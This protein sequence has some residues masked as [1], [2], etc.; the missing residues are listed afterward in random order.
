MIRFI[1]VSY[2]SI[3]I[4]ALAACE[5]EYDRLS[6]RWP[7][8][9]PPTPIEGTLTVL[10]VKFGIEEFD[11]Q[12]ARFNVYETS[13]G[14]VVFI[15]HVETGACTKSS[16]F[17]ET[18]SLSPFIEAATP[19]APGDFPLVPGKLIHQLEGYDRDRGVHL[20]NMYYGSHNNIDD[21]RIKIHSASQETIEASI[22]G[23]AV[24]NGS[25]YTDPDAWFSV[26]GNFLRDRE[27]VG[28][29]Q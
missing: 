7:T 1:A 21:L 3:A 27:L 6:R 19:L 26:R 4:L 10:H 2:L 23:C 29:L 22:T 17:H 12:T 8:L 28:H 9:E 24:V 5:S 18:I 14:E 25:L 20:T 11:I 13:D 15:V 16:E